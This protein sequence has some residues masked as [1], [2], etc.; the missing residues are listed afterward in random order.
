MLP[1]EQTVKHGIIRIHFVCLKCAKK[2]WNKVAEDDELSML[3]PKIEEYK[4]QTFMKL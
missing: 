4:I 3:L 1:F 2:H